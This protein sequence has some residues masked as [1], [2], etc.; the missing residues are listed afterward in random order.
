MKRTA[1]SAKKRLTAIPWAMI[2]GDGMGRGA[3]AMRDGTDV[4]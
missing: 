1:A 4:G 3:A 2:A